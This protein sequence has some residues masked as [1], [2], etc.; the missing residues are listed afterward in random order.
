MQLLLDSDAVYLVAPQAKRSAIGY[1]YLSNRN[2]SDPTTTRPPLNAPIHGECTFLRN[3]I[4]SAA[5]AETGT[6]FHN[7]KVTRGLK[8]CQKL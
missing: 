7:Y 3:V 1:S 4:S 5:E 6:L 8:I 2:T